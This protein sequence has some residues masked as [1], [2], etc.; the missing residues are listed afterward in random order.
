MPLFR[1]TN[2][3]CYYEQDLSMTIQKHALVVFAV[4]LMLLL[5]AWL[6]TAEPKVWRDRL[7]I[8][9]FTPEENRHTP[10]EPGGEYLPPVITASRVITAS[11]GPIVIAG[12]VTIPAGIT[13]TLEA[14]AHMLV[15]EYG[16]LRVEGSL[17]IQGS[18]DAPV[19]LATNELHPSNRV[20]GGIIF[21]P[22]STGAISHTTIRHASPAITCENSSTVSITESILEWGNTGIVADSQSC[23]IIHTTIRHVD[24]GIVALTEPIMRNVVIQARKHDIRSPE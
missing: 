13:L 5:A 23:S 3:R 6:E 4:L 17:Q 24:T 7:F 11:E 1:V 22:D 16:L 9:D 20:W 12:E 18:A 21:T 10:L 2:A 15:H 19:T 8:P 14:G